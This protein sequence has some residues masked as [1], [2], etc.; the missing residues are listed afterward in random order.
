M[1]KP[2][3]FVGKELNIGDEVVFMQLKYRNLLKGKI[4]KITKNTI[5]IDHEKTNNYQVQTK[6]HSSQVVKIN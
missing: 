4:S 6:Q 3:D 1:D 5:W 2:L